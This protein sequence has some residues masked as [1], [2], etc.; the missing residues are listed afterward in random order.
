MGHGYK[1]EEEKKG[2]SPAGMA[3]HAKA[4]WQDMKDHWEEAGK[5]YSTF[6]EKVGN[7][8]LAAGNFLLTG[9]NYVVAGIS[10]P[11]YYGGIGAY[12]A[13]AWAFEKGAVK[14]WIAEA[15]KD[16]KD[17]IAEAVRDTRKTIGKGATWVWEHKAQV[18]S[19]LVAGYIAGGVFS[20]S[21][22]AGGVSS[23]AALASG[24]AASQSTMS[25]SSLISGVTYYLSQKGAAALTGA[26][27][28]KNKY[29]PKVRDAA[30]DAYDYLTPKARDAAIAAAPVVQAVGDYVGETPSLYKG[31]LVGSKI[32]PRYQEAPAEE[33]AAAQTKSDSGQYQNNTSQSANDTKQADP[34]P[35]PTNSRAGKMTPQEVEEELIQKMGYEQGR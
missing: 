25:I 31:L 3:G 2:Y 15:A 14:D 10:A 11:F 17:W 4:A 18:V 22:A 26:K 20:A 28:A 7:Y 30:I 29:G 16:T 13:G 12:N 6:W 27:K 19:Y 32:K 35:A 34:N 24:E 9:V 8:A 33:P 21:M 23:G 1:P 5:S